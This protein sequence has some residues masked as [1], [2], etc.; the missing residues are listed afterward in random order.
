M[1][2]LP[3]FKKRRSGE[4]ADASSSEVEA[5]QPP[6][7]VPATGETD[8]AEPPADVG[9]HAAGH[10]LGGTTRRRRR[11]GGRGRGGRGR[12][13]AGQAPETAEAVA[14]T[15]ESAVV[16]TTEGVAAAD[17]STR[18]R[19]RRARPVDTG[20]SPAEQKE[21]MAA[22]LPAPARRRTRKK[23]EEPVVAPVEA[24]APPAATRRRGGR[25]ARPAPSLAPNGAPLAAEAAVEAP[26]AAALPL[27]P[28]RGESIESLVARQNV[29]LEMTQR[30][31]AVIFNDIRKSIGAIERRLTGAELPSGFTSLPR[32]GVF[33]DV[34]NVVYAAEKLGV[35]IDFGRLL[36]LVTRGRELVR[37]AA[38]APISDNPAEPVEQQHYV[39]P[40]IGRGFRIIT[41]PLKRFSDGSVKANFDVELAI[42]I[43]TMSERL[44]VVVL[45]SGDGDFRRIV[46]LVESRGV[47][48]EVVSFG[49]ATSRD[50][51]MTADSFVD[52]QDHLEELAG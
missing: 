29:L 38:Y 12:G 35:R 48:V 42:D 40:F 20:V 30:E 33:V 4:G 47:R 34:P 16:P 21:A 37:A 9:D 17:G 7:F 5:A 45:V 32:T 39:A 25:A 11:R 49:S 18:G 31:Q 52:L 3:L 50:L 10:D 44:D 1:A 14:P 8:Q 27:A 6:H 51:A 23:A 13:A 24:E 19:R 43:L 2:F 28:R 22:A 46:E 26:P 15:R 41:K 36:E